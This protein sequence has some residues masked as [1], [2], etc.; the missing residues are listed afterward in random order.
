MPNKAFNKI[1]DPFLTSNEFYKSIDRK[2]LFSYF[3]SIIY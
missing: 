2:I 1:Q 3:K